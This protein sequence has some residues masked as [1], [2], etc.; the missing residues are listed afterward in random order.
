MLT[1]WAPHAAKRRRFRGSLAERLA[2]VLTLLALFS[3][4]AAGA[5]EGPTGA[6]GFELGAHFDANSAL[7]VDITPQGHASYEVAAP[8]PYRTFD[9]YNLVVTPRSHRIAIISAQRTFGNAAA[10]LQEREAIAAELRDH[11]GAPEVHPAPYPTLVFQ[12]GH[13][14]V[15]LYC[16]PT[17]DGARLVLLYGS[18]P[19]IARAEQERQA[20]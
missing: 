3:S 20:P 7:S 9:Q 14:I 18:Q 15:L 13:A 2:L 10:C 17:S 16:K 1:V 12:P 6:F 8:Q 4:A 19:L 11:Y 5:E